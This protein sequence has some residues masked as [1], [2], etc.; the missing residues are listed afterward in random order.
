MGWLGV[1]TPDILDVRAT[2]RGTCACI[3]GPEI[4]GSRPGESHDGK[5]GH[6]AK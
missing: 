3:G 4:P 1:L 6:A 5:N 2:Y